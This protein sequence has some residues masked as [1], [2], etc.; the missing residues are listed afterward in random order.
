MAKTLSI[1]I[2]KQDDDFFLIGINA[3]V[4]DYQMTAILNKLLNIK[5]SL[6]ATES[7]FELFSIYNSKSPLR[8]ACLIHNISTT[9][10]HA[11]EKL[12][13]FEYLLL[14]SNFDLDLINEALSNHQDIIYFSNVDAEKLLKREFAKLKNLLA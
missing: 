14:L 3:F 1:D 13:S 5:L 12:K 9:N 10:A 7:E 6:S 8:E 11:F 2:D 4:K